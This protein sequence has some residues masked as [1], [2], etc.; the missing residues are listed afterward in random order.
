MCDLCNS[1]RIKQ[2][3]SHR[4]N[5]VRY[6]YGICKKCSYVYQYEKYM[7]THYEDLPCQGQSDYADHTKRRANYIVNFVD[8]HLSKYSDL[9]ILD[10]GCG[11]GGVMKN[12]KDLISHSSIFGY[13][14]DT[15]KPSIDPTLNIIYQ[16]VE[17]GKGERDPNRYDLIVMSHV[18]EHFYN[19]VKTLTTIKDSLKDDGIVYIEVPSFING[20]VRVPTIFCPEHI[21]F[22]TIDSLSVLL[23]Q[24]GYEIVKVLDSKFWGNIKV[25]AKRSSVKQTIKHVPSRVTLLIKFFARLKYPF[26]RLLKRFVKVGPN[27]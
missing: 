2:L 3:Y 11:E 21:S 20:E 15:G 22:F 10:I 17:T 26:V 23:N 18:V 13:T 16:N 6:S 9:K 5:G 19:P 24:C 8:E 1:N 12:L 4:V 27:E 7:R 25:V 14:L